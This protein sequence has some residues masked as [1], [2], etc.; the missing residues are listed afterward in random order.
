MELF[1]SDSIF[2]NTSQSNVYLGRDVVGKPNTSLVEQNKALVQQIKAMI[3]SNP[4]YD[5][6]IVDMLETVGVPITDQCSILDQCHENRFTIELFSEIIPCVDF[7]IQDLAKDLQCSSP[8]AALIYNHF[9]ESQ[10]PPIIQ[11]TDLVTTPMTQKVS[12]VGPL[13]QEPIRV[14]TIHMD[15]EPNYYRGTHTTPMQE[16]MYN[17]TT[18]SKDS[19]FGGYDYLPKTEDIELGIPQVFPDHGIHAIY[20]DTGGNTL[21]NTQGMNAFVAATHVAFQQH[22][23]L[24]MCPAT[25]WSVIVSSLVI[26]INQESERLRQY[27][28]NHQGQ[29]PIKVIDDTL[30][31]FSKHNQWA[32]VFQQFAH[33]IQEEVGDEVSSLFQSNFSTTTTIHQVAANVGI[34]A[35]T[36]SLFTFVMCTRCGITKFNLEGTTEDWISI[37]ERV[38]AFYKVDPEL[39]WWITPLTQLID[40]F[41]EA[42]NGNHDKAFWS[43]WYKYHQRSGGATITGNINVLFPWV[44]NYKREFVKNT[45][46]D[47]VTPETRYR[48]L[49]SD[50]H[51]SSSYTAPVLWEYMG[52]KI[53]IEFTSGL[54][55]MV[56]S[57]EKGCKAIPGFVVAEVRE[58]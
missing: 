33:K 3:R 30:R 43:S 45:S 19:P 44:Y 50:A 37:R 53:P 39:A 52:E 17:K 32:P 13:S 40:K 27:L 9:C 36:K 15:V 46:V 54:M 18:P 28:V 42:S 8:N 21:H 22:Q 38:Q 49:S 16:Y 26:H 55:G 24:T 57:E 7:T 41:I 35:A 47:I 34:M 51:P 56:H 14:V 6:A 1:N 5:N 48:G 10:V 23:A 29:K 11:V 20:F 4:H 25:I 31:K 12:L 2:T 58:S